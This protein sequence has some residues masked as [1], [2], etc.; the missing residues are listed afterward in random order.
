MGLEPAGRGTLALA[1]TDGSAQNTI[2]SPL[3]QPQ[4]NTLRHRERSILLAEV[5]RR[6]VTASLPPG[7][8]QARN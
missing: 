1:A 7:V 3:L 8:P 4:W 5:G 6:S 2:P